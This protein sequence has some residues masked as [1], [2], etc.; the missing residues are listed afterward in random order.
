M[1]AAIR[2]L[3]VEDNP[4]DA[5]FIK[6]S[7]KEC[8][9]LFELT[10][11][12]QLADI[13]PLNNYNVVLLDLHLPDSNGLATVLKLQQILTGV[14]VIVFTNLDND[15]VSLASIQSGAQDYLVKGKIDSTHLQKTI[16]YAIQRYQVLIKINS[17][18][19]QRKA[20]L[21]THDVLTGLLNQPA[22]LEHLEL[23]LSRNHSNKKM[24]A[25]LF[26]EI[27]EL[28]KIISNYGHAAK[29]Q[30][31]KNINDY[32]LQVYTLYEISAARYSENIF[33][34]LLPNLRSKQEV[35][36]I[37]LDL[38]KTLSKTVLIND[39][40][41]FISY[42]IGVACIQARVSSE[43]LIK[44]TQQAL[45]E[46]YQLG[47]KKYKLLTQDSIDLSSSD[48]AEIWLSDLQFALERN[49]FFLVYQPQINAKSQKISGVE[50]LL[51]WKHPKYGLISPE[52]FIPI[53]EESRLIIPIGE[54]V[55]ET[56]VK[57]FKNWHDN[58]LS[59]FDI[60]LSVNIS[61]HQLVDNQLIQKVIDL[62]NTYRLN[63]NL[64]ELEL[65]ESVFI[66]QPEKMI[67]KLNQFQKL[68]LRTAIDDYG[69]GYSSLSYLSHLP[70][71]NLKIDM[72]FVQRCLTDA[73]TYTIMKSTIDLAH[74]LNL[75]VIA[76]G[77][78]TKEQFEILKQ[79]QC[80][81]VQG[82]LFSKP[83][84]PH[85]FESFLLNS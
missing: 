6:E 53:A 41:Y 23:T 26:I 64:L 7:L 15:E 1:V 27:H 35:E 81:E 76:E 42:N 69:R 34:L 75:G 12:T 85:E 2:I 32:L 37:I 11:V 66:T 9:I 72:T 40:E 20:Y 19:D 50:A 13:D 28:E 68:G 83:L 61:V 31:L 16:L 55:L 5:L 74:S 73:A 47:V 21:S 70:I 71:N 48:K 52:K 36:Q 54:W 59:P 60:R 82:Y 56:A 43:L 22:F 17:L 77:V 25:L 8:S 14:P 18:S 46:A 39:H 84:L 65:T 63:P 30:I 57:Q 51:R 67:K 4:G 33:A 38:N 44:N 80:D 3:L 49:E 24:L 29:D 10:H 58:L 62:L 78:E 45:K 79:Q